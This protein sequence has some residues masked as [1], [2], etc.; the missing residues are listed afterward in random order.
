VLINDQEQFIKAQFDNEAEID[1]V[2]QRYAEQLFGSSSIYLPKT[3]ITTSGGRGT[4]PDAFVIDIQSEEW[5]V[6]EAER[7]V[8][9]TW[10]HIAP[11]ISKQ[12]A[13][14]ASIETRDLLLQIALNLIGANK[15]LR[16]IFQ[17]LGIGELE[18]H[19]KL[20]RILRKPPTIAIPIDRIPK[21]L[22]DW[23]QTLKNNT[24]I[25]VIEK[26]VSINNPNRVLYSLPDE[27][28][29]T[30]TTI[31]TQGT[32]LSSVRATGSQPF[33]EVLDAGLLSEGQIL[34]MD[35]GPRGAER[36]TFQGI[37][38]KEGIEVDGTVYSPSYAAVHCIQQLGSNRKTANGWIMW[39]TQSG[40]LLN[41]L[42][43]Q[44]DGIEE[45]TFVDEDAT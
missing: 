7:A 38:R 24:K 15:A 20:Q 23:V 37:V 34:F 17:D 9:G 28:L 16:D 19:G 11:Q 1:G 14:V 41:D 3:K 31:S 33:Q 40:E 25:W 32:S 35:Y 8:H 26:Y 44:L 6:V 12:L 42:Y 2:V 43:G 4:I 13:A 36:R 30:L 21:D 10:E 18:I 29:P 22:T 39:K 27:N 45:K 5:Y